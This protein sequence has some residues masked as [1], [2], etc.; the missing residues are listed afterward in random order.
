MMVLCMAFPVSP[1]TFLRESNISERC[2]EAS[3]TGRVRQALRPE[4]RNNACGGNFS[5]VSARGGIAS[6]KALVPHARAR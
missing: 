3:G 6:E 1:S 5:G 4:G 2:G